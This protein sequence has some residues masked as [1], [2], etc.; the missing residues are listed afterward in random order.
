MDK[1]LLSEFWFRQHAISKALQVDA[2]EEIEV[3]IDDDGELEPYVEYSDPITDE[4][5]I[6]YLESRPITHLGSSFFSPI[7]IHEG[8]VR[9]ITSRVDDAHSVFLSDEQN[10]WLRPWDDEKLIDVLA[11]GLV[12]D[13][14]ENEQ[15]QDLYNSDSD[16]DP[17]R[18]ELYAAVVQELQNR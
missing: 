16:V 1:N 2:P 4:Q 18:D 9:H 10:S 7:K 5:R 13:N 8:I 14:A 15:R 3:I 12:K 17:D 6:I 11:F